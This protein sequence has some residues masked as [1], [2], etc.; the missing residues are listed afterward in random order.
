M[1]SVYT[2][3]FE[4]MMINQ[5]ARYGIGGEDGELNKFPTTFKVASTESETVVS[6]MSLM[7]KVQTRLNFV[8][9][10]YSTLVEKYGTESIE[11]T[12]PVYEQKISGTGLKTKTLFNGE[13]H[14]KILQVLFFFEGEDSATLGI[15]KTYTQ[16]YYVV[17]D[18]E[19]K[20]LR[21]TANTIEAFSPEKDAG[22]NGTYQGGGTQLY[23]PDAAKNATFTP[24]N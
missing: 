3:T 17:L 6:D 2:T 16:K 24:V 4:V 14:E 13:S 11:L 12:K 5:T 23:S 9:K 7:Q 8:V 18:G 22:V 21:S 19:Y 10:K 1:K 15:P 20:F